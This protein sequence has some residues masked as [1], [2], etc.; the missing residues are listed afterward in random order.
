[1]RLHMPRP[2]TSGCHGA[3]KS[4]PKKIVG[5]LQCQTPILYVIRMM[6][7]MAVYSST[8]ICQFSLLLGHLFSPLLPVFFWCDF[9]CCHSV[10]HSAGPSAAHPLLL[11]DCLILR[12]TAGF[13]F[14]L[15]PDLVFPPSFRPI[16]SYHCTTASAHTPHRVT[17]C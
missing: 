9:Y 11:Y 2:E 4:K 16:S 6:V 7:V 1:V 13:K 8:R 17:T 10:L 14:L 3:R 12:F 5:N 15:L